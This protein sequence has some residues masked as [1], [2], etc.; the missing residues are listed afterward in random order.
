VKQKQSFSLKVLDDAI[1]REI[2]KCR[3]VSDLLELLTYPLSQGV[4]W[5]PE[6]ARALLEQELERR[7]NQGHDMLKHALGGRDAEAFVAVRLTAIQR[8]LDAMYK[9]LGREGPVPTEQVEA[10]LKD[11]EQRLTQAL[12][13]RIT[14]SVTYNRVAPPELAQGAEDGNWNQ[15][16]TL[17]E[18]AART[19]RKSYTDFYFPRRLSGTRF[20]LDE[21]RKALDIFGDHALGGGEGAYLEQ[22]LQLL[23]EI[24]TSD[25][26]TR[27]KCLEVWRLTK[28]LPS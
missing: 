27:D 12:T 11:I 3:R 9:E 2:E 15:P 22:E 21:F 6:S 10:V 18:C 23:D 14:P 7:D 28:G 20:S 24:S 19:V 17:L 25:K 4:R 5:V 13:A 26:L 8:D 1:D 16:F